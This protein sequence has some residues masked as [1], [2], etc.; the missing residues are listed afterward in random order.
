MK[1]KKELLEDD[2][3]RSI[4]TLYHN[5]PRKRIKGYKPIKVENPKI[6]NLVETK[7]YEAG[8]LPSATPEICL[9]KLV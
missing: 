9:S 3:V 8:Y 2:T 5:C 7:P 1:L 6:L 4:L